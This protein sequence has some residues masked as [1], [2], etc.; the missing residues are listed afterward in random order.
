[1]LSDV[2]FD[3]R[4]SVGGGLTDRLHSWLHRKGIARTL[5]R[6]SNN[7]SR[8]ATS[9][10]ETRG[11]RWAGERLWRFA[12]RHSTCRPDWLTVKVARVEQLGRR[13]YRWLVEYERVLS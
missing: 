6:T 3:D 4:G 12:L 13:H 5:N 9:Y 2:E 8:A 7:Y 10:I 1:M 11:P